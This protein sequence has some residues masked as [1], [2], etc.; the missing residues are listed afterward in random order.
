MFFPSGCFLCVG[1]WCLTPAVDLPDDHFGKRY[2]A[3]FPVPGAVEHSLDPERLIRSLLKYDQLK[4]CK[5]SGIRIKTATCQLQQIIQNGSA[6]AG[7][8][9]LIFRQPGIYISTT[10]TLFPCSVMRLIKSFVF[11]NTAAVFSL[12]CTAM[13]SENAAS[14]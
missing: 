4:Q 14:R 9:S 1:L 5:R 2:G 3:F 6:S 13:S 11:M 12:G 8:D 10:Q 7:P